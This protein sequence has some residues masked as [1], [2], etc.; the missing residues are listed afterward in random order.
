MKKNTKNVLEFIMVLFLSML[1]VIP[2]IMMLGSKEVK[3]G[4]HQSAEI[5]VRE[6]RQ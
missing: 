4:R 3:K 2:T 1:F 6:I 5:I